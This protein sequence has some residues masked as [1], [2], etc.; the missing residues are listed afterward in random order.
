M[1]CWCQHEHDRI[2]QSAPENH[3]E[4]SPYRVASCSGNAHKGVGH[5]AVDRVKWRHIFPERLLHKT[6][7]T[8]HCGN[9]LFFLC[10]P[11]R[12]SGWAALQLSGLWGHGRPLGSCLLLR[13]VVLPPLYLYEPARHRALWNVQ[14]A[15]QLKPFTLDPA[16]TPFTDRAQSLHQ[17]QLRDSDGVTD[18]FFSRLTS[19]PLPFP[20]HRLLWR[21]EGF[22]RLHQFHWVKIKLNLSFFW[23]VSLHTVA[24][25]RGR[26]RFR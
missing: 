17:D 8:L 14:P 6:P 4:R 16:S 13:H 7:S 23:F 10:C 1:D 15:P 5:S 11:S 2:S 9:I 25:L 12:Y 21:A 24:F 26:I 22:A 3:P 19:K 18:L 20:S